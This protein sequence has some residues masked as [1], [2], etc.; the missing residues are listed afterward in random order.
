[1]KKVL[2]AVILSSLF[3]S[4]NSFAGSEG[5]S[6]FG[7]SYHMGT[8]EED[9]LPSADLTGLNIKGGAYI[10]DNV[11]V[12]GRYTLGMDSDTVSVF[13]PGFGNVDVE[14]ELDS[15]ISIFVK[16]DLPVSNAANIYGLIG[17][18]KAELTAT[19]LGSSYTDDDSGL[20]YGFGVEAAINDDMFI[21][22]E[23]IM[24]LDEDD[25]EYTGINIGITKL[26]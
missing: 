26:F 6:Y 24:Y 16:G 17:F 10:A 19:V 13:V 15:A 8:Y 9:G 7:A 18:T 25:Y 22:G 1:M 4:M 3:L 14:L 2:C 5:Q 20:S 11:A 12:E 23:Y 21:N